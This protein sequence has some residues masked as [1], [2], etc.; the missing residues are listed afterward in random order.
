MISRN[1]RMMNTVL[2]LFFAIAEYMVA[3]APGSRVR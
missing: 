2:R 1:N 3:E